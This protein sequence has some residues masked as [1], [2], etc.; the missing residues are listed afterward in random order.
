MSAQTASQLVDRVVAGFNSGDIASIAEAFHP[1][2][3]AEFPFA[4]PGMPAACVGHEDT[5]AAFHGGRANFATMKLIPGRSYW[6]PDSSMYV[7]E[8]TSDAKLAHGT[9]YRNAYVFLIEIR[10][11]RISLWREYFNSMVVVQAL[12]AE[13]AAAG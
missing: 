9:E 7:M 13:M 1:Q 6:C 8:A 5:M 12:E 10:D 11:G 2:V 4:P 3:R